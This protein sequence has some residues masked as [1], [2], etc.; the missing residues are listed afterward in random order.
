[1][2]REKP[3]YR[4]S[5]HAP[6][7]GATERYLSVQWRQTYFNSRPCGRGDVAA[8][9][10]VRIEGQFQFTP[11][12]EGR[13]D[14][15]ALLVAVQTISIHAPAGGATDAKYSATLLIPKF[16]FTPLREGRLSAAEAFSLP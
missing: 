5:I 12:R 6:A 9:V 13:R 8:P 7:G 16:Q 1:M 2:P 15:D 11:L 14:A 10:V 4:I 3:L